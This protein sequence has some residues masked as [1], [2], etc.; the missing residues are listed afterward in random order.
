M[1]HTS[2]YK[3]TNLNFANYQ[4]RF[5]QL[6]IGFELELEF[7]YIRDKFIE[8]FEKCFGDEQIFF[9]K[10]DFSLSPTEGI[11]IVSHPITFEYINIHKNLF[12]KLFALIDKYNGQAKENCGLHFHLD[13]NYM[14]NNA[15]SIVDMLVNTNKIY[16]E[17]LGNRKENRFSNFV[18]KSRFDWGRLVHFHSESKYC[19]VNIGCRDTIELRFFRSVNN[20][21]EFMKKIIIAYKIGE[22][23]KQF[24][25]FEDFIFYDYEHETVKEFEKF[26]T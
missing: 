10:E 11:E 23:S 1:V 6:H 21:N 18:Y 17:K 5:N 12:I 2:S 4:N 16:F 3:P 26:L 9:L 15:V 19:A 8:E 14:N 7:E 25:T 22:F 24:K 20:L 13:R